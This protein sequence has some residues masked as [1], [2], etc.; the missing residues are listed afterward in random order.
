[1]TAVFVTGAGTDIGKTFVTAA[2]IQQLRKDGRGVRALKPVMTG[3]GEAAIASDA[4][5]LLKSMGREVSELEISR[6]SP[7]RY[8]APLSPDMAAARE[9]SVI[10]Y[11]G[12]VDFCRGEVTSADRSGDI[13]LIEGIGGLMVPLTESKTVADWI[14]ALELPALLVT[15]SYLGSLSHT[16]TALR[17]AA[18]QNIEILAVV[19]SESE[20]GA[21]PL[22]ETVDT[23]ERFSLGLPVFGLPRVGSPSSAPDLTALLP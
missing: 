13:V 18:S 10:D 8:D 21:A 4:A 7:W 19:V 15:G 5:L 20:A 14:S 3:A 11:Q 9:G 6:I 16:L 2:L 22:G 17:A 12:L 23:I 1:M